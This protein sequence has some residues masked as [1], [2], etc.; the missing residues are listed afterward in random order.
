MLGK[1][2]EEF[3]TKFMDAGGML[4]SS[5]PS[6]PWN[7]EVV[8]KYKYHIYQG[9]DANIDVDAYRKSSLCLICYSLIKPNEMVL[10]C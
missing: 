7:V 9:K 8:S 5:S 4:V 3:A 1:N 10:K 6:Q 2:D